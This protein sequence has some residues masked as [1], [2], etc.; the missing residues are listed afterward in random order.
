ME[1]KLVVNS[2]RIEAMFKLDGN[3]G[4]TTAIAFHPIMGRWGVATSMCM[5]SKIED[6][7]VVKKCF[8][9]AFEELEN[10]DT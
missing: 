1:V 9:L 4:W 5:P 10:Y 7:L 8:D 2:S 6:A 3:D